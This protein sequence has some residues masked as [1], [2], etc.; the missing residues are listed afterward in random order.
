[1]EIYEIKNL[2][3]RIKKNRQKLA[4]EVAALLGRDSALSNEQ[5]QK[6]AEKISK[7]YK[8]HISQI[9]YSAERMEEKL[10]WVFIDIDSGYSQY[11]ANSQYEVYAKFI[12]LVNEYRK[13]IGTEVKK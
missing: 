6:A 8:F 3:C 9:Q 12:L 4:R 13:I 5:I 10:C 1:M 2:D 11:R 7:K